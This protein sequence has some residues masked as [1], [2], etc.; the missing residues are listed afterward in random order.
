MYDWPEARAETDA[1]WI[2]LRDAMR[3]AG[4]PA[5]DRL[6]RRNADLPPVPG[7]IRDGAGTVIAPDPATLPPDGIDL[8]TLWRHPRLLFAQACWGT[9][10]LGLANHVRVIGQPDYSAYQ[11]GAGSCYSSAILMRKEAAAQWSD[12]S[13]P[14]PEN[15]RPSL[16][17]DMLRGRRFAYNGLDSMSGIIALTRDLEAA[18][19]SIGI[20]GERI[21]TG[22]HRASL[23]AVA[24]GRAEVCAIDC[25]T[26]ALA[27][28][29]EPRAA[30]LS[31]VG[32]TRLRPGLP[33]ITAMETP[34]EIVEVLCDLL[35]PS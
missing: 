7:G 25:R 28:R 9:L 2:G 23:I 8:H 6:V 22:S 5:P 19:E 31:V 20:F 12:G 35:S 32:W 10:E 1:A 18:S 14:A 21:E 11:G 30:K 24:E 16:P 13:V 3:A 26:W 15:G 27:K 29:F 34:Q 4:L 33:Y 17:L